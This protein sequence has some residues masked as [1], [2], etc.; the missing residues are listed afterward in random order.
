[1]RSMTEASPRLTARIAGFFYLLTFITGVIALVARG[2]MPAFTANIIASACYVGVTVLFYD[3]FKPVDRG[4]SSL[5]AL[6]S[7]V[8]NISRTR[9]ARDRNVDLSS[10]RISLLTTWCRA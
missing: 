7:L 4:V 5:A 10:Q 8:G 6:I 1:M 3:L 2:G 9:T